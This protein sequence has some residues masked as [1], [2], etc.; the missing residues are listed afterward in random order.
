MDEA[1]QLALEMSAQNWMNFQNDLTGLSPD[2][3][4]WRPLPQANH[5]SAIIKHLR[6][7]EEWYVTGIEHGEQSPYHDAASLEQ[8][9]NT[10]PLDFAQN[11]KDLEMLHHR[12]LAAVRR[13]TLAALRRQT[14][15]SQAMPG[16]SPQPAHTLLLREMTHLAMHRGQIRTI[17][18]LYRTT[19]GEAGLFVPH[20]PLFAE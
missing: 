4:Q 3:I 16:Q 19:R 6:V 14:F 15:L 9:T 13:T 5:I 1:L 12:F 8:L 11:V 10:V 17:R 2:E 7:T 18:N 20:N